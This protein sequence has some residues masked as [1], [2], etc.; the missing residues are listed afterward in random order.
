M[1]K[2]YSCK[3]KDLDV[4]AEKACHYCDDFTAQFADV[5]VG[6]VG[7]KKGYSTVI[8]RSK[9]GEKLLKNLNAAKE[10]VDKE[11]IARLVKIQERTCQKKLGNPKQGVNNTCFHDVASESV[12][13]KSPTLR[14]QKPF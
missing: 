11:E 13:L 5:S 3:V 12:K 8:V 1:G 9:A 2:E 14:M 7:S 4:A 6:S 10:L